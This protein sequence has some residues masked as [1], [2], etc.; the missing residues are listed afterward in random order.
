MKILAK[1]FIILFLLLTI[2]SYNRY[3]T[4]N[5]DGDGDVFYLDR[6]SLMCNDGEAL[7]QFHLY[8]PNGNRIAYEYTCIKNSAINA[9]DSYNDQTSTTKIDDPKE[10]TNYLDRLNVKCKSDYVLVGFKLKKNGNNIYYSFRCSGVKAINCNTKNTGWTDGNIGQTP[11]LDRQNF[12]LG[13][14]E[15][16]QGFHLEVSY[17]D[18]GWLRKNG[19]N[20]RYNLPYCEIRDVDSE[21]ETYTKNKHKDKHR[22]LKYLHEIIKIQFKSSVNKSVNNP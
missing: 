3:T 12:S 15:L 2:N 4:S 13:T 11:Y 7:S 20:M 1:F 16:L 10:N 18:R 17:Y 14:N 9:I 22:G 21:K 19:F 6:H 8:R 5:D